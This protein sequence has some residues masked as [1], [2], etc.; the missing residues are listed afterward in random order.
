LLA[1]AAGLGIVLP[2]SSWGERFFTQELP[3]HAGLAVSAELAI[4][5]AATLVISLAVWRGAFQARRM[6]AAGAGPTS[7]LRPG[8]HRFDRLW[9]DFRDF[10]GIV[11]ARRILDRVNFTA[12]E[13]NW[14]LRLHLDG[15]APF[16]SKAGRSG[17]VPSHEVSAAESQKIE[18]ALR[19][20]LRRFVDPQ[21]IDER[22]L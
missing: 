19:W 3:I 4:H 11:W 15:F 21:W 2:M 5:A 10:F 18:H 16:D 12:G 9:S 14:P 8:I 1:S 13:Q 7:E 6:T 22:L 17:A 20:L